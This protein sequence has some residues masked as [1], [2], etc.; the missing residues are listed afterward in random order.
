MFL[1]LF[2]K[3]GDVV[4]P[5]PK[6]DGLLAM[7]LLM[8]LL[9]LLLP[10]TDFEGLP[11]AGAL[12]G[13]AAANEANPPEVLPLPNTGASFDAAKFPKPTGF[14]PKTDADDFLLPPEPKPEVFPKTGADAVPPVLKVEVVPNTG[15]PPP[16]PKVEVA[17]KT[18]AELDGVVFVFSLLDDPNPPNFDALPNTA[19]ELGVVDPNPPVLPKAGVAL[20]LVVLPVVDVLKAPPLVAPNVL[21]PPKGEAVVV[22]LPNAL[23]LPNTEAPLETPPKGLLLLP[24]ASPIPSDG[25]S[26]PEASISPHADITT[27]RIGLD[28]LLVS[29]L[30]NSSRTSIPS[31][32]WPKITCFPLRYGTALSVKKN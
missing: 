27:S 16:E 18:G 2:P 25:L 8:L 1:L 22:P 17:P 24:S 29:T 12:P 3:A 5:P 32:T 23:V 13:A 30:L 26:F 28:A 11:N 19:T 10:K 31:S 4:V 14:V 21:L 20:E 9:L 6:T 7:S 15:F